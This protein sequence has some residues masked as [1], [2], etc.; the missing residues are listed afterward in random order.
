MTDW[1][2]LEHNIRCAKGE[3]EKRKAHIAIRK[4]VEKAQPFELREIIKA[5]ENA[6]IRRQVEIELW[7]RE[8]DKKPENL[9]ELIQT[10]NDKNKIVNAVIELGNLKCRDAIS[11]LIS[12]L[13]DIDLRDS[14]AMALRQMPT[15]EAFEPL[16]K[17][18]K[19]YDDGVECLLYALQVLDCSDAAELLVDLF[20]SKPNALAIRDDIYVCFKEKAVKRIS[21]QIKDSCCTKILMAI[22]ESRDRS[23]TK[24]LSQLFEVLNQIEED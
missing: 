12:F 5:T 24:E 13:D 8:F 17:S 9:L 7:W 11:M 23:N 3:K 20:I 1:K 19:Q 2:S 18:I 14:A 10:S 6:F 4:Y 16:I 21:K 22:K 15:Q